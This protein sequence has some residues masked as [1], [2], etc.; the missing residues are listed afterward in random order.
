M[1][2]SDEEIESDDAGLHPRKRHNTVSMAKILGGIGDALGDK[3][4]VPIQKKE[5][6]VPGSLILPHPPLTG[7]LSTDLGSISM[8]RSMLGFHG[9]SSPRRG[10]QW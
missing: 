2:S 1:L 5:M 3:F 10:L 6:V 7:A 9:S 4:S 8:F